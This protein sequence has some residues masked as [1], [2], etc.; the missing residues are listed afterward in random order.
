MNH[1]LPDPAEFLVLDP[2]DDSLDAQLLLQGFEA[3]NQ[4]TQKLQ[5]YYRDIELKVD[6]LTGELARKNRE[7][8]QNL[9]EKEQVKSYLTSVFE[10]SA[11]GILVTDLQ[12]HVTSVNQ[13]TLRL[14]DRI[15]EEVQGAHLNEL[16]REQLLPS[17]ITPEFMQNL[18]QGHEQELSLRQ[19]SGLTR[20]LRIYLSLMKSDQNEWLGIIVNV[21]DITDLKKLEEEAE[22]K[23]RFT[24]MGQMAASIA[25][26][27][28]NPL[29]SIE[30]FT[31]LLRKEVETDSAQRLVQHI[32]SA[33]QSMNH[34]ISNL[35]EYTK[36]RPVARD[37]IDLHVFL[38]GHLSFFEQ[39]VEYNDVCIHTDFH[40]A[41][42]KVR[43]ESEL[44]K[45]VFHNILI[46]SVQ[47]MVETGEIRI[48]TRNVLTDNR[49]MLERF[50]FMP[51]SQRRHG[52]SLL[53]V[54]IRD[55]G[56]GMPAEV[57]KRIFDPF[58]TTKERGTGLGLA[59]VHNIVES[60]G[61]IIDV[62]SEVERGTCFTLLF[63]VA[64]DE[65]VAEAESA[66][67]L[68]AGAPY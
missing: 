10:S 29:G 56:G 44:L 57:R 38:R 68:S 5:S 64:Q 9:Q 53:Q 47:A 3:F 49:K 23:N 25:H 35:L 32:G 61:A 43:G 67:E 46:N 58:F 42:T 16:F 55:T 15:A 60:H 14:L 18:Q 1:E 27:I 11:I 66:S 2:E 45:Q 17:T 30:L 36:P 7:L 63:P 8:E 20:K 48:T 22:R 24:G 28:R 6:E 62:E 39:L 37:I 51:Q 31:S 4:A 26:E 65:D 33:V 13:K 41:S 59:I 34:I 54:T 52:L 21:Q 12:G 19:A 50:S 40:A